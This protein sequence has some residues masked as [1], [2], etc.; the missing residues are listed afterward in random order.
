MN[1]LRHYLAKRRLVK[2][3]R[4]ERARNKPWALNRAAQLDGE[5]RKRFLATFEGLR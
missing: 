4:K 2:L 5:R 1:L 3:V